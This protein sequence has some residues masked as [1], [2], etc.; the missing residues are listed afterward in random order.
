MDQQPRLEVYR[1]YK[2]ATKYVTTWLVVKGRETQYPIDLQPSGVPV[3]TLERLADWV[4]QKRLRVPETVLKALDLVIVLR[5]RYSA[6][7]RDRNNLSTA[8]H[9]HLYFIQALKSIQASLQSLP[10]IDNRPAAT[11]NISS[12]SARERGF[13]LLHNPDLPDSNT[14]SEVAECANLLSATGLQSGAQYV[15][16]PTATKDEALFQ[17]NLLCEEFRQVRETVQVLWIRYINGK[18]D[19]TAALCATNMAVLLS[20]AAESEIRPAMEQFMI[21]NSSVR[22]SYTCLVASSLG[23]NNNLAK[24]MLH[25]VGVQNNRVSLATV[26]GLETLLRVYEKLETAGKLQNPTETLRGLLSSSITGINNLPSWLLSMKVD[27]RKTL[28][29]FLAPTHR[30]LQRLQ[31]N[32]S[33]KLISSE[34]VPSST[35]LRNPV[36]CGLIVNYIRITRQ[37]LGLSLERNLAG[38]TAVVHTGKALVKEQY[39][40][41][42]FQT[43]D[44]ARVYHEQKADTFFIGGCEP[45]GIRKQEYL[46]KCSLT[47]GASI[48]NNLPS[49]RPGHLSVRKEM[50]FFTPKAP[51][52]RA[53]DESFRD[54][55]QRFT[56][57][58]DNLVKMLSTHSTMMEKKYKAGLSAQ[59]NPLKDAAMPFPTLHRKTT[60]RAV[61]L[62]SSGS[63]TVSDE[64]QP[65]P[66]V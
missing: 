56:L 62:L 25:D 35:L 21:S 41:K 15:L 32:Q 65:Q 4:V 57:N 24:E 26:F 1:Q 64:W 7:M 5:T 52:S 19:L 18:T 59:H 10:Q 61:N 63:G 13:S 34:Q 11:D 66:F 22:D 39:L 3:A 9:T 27:G 58:C 8:D 54:K 60:M 43:D 45:S 6:G 30:Y 29:D 37:N 40:T 36:L 14:E 46:Q 51:F 53:V 47:I 55:H 33:A 38:I 44:I 31:D 28:D 20:Q 23:I 2:D 49:S 42:A 17:F 48:T 12:N 16:R 50:K